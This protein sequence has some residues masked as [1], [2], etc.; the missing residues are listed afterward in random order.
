MEKNMKKLNIILLVFSMLVS[1]L[2]FAYENPSFYEAATNETPILKDSPVKAIQTTIIKLNQLTNVATYSPQMMGFLVNREITPLFDF[3][4]IA[5][6]V[7]SA[8]HVNL[9][10]EEVEYFANSLRQNVINTLL[11]KLA[12]GRSSSLDFVYARPM[13]GNMI[14]VRLNAK[15]Y[16][17][18]G[19]NVDLSFHKSKSGKWQIF[20]VALGHD[21]LIN[22]YQR[23]VLIK[24]RRYGVYGMLGRI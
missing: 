2:V 16:S 21:N 7:L 17:R 14:V 3:E 12:Q 20:D 24:V 9:N 8:S 22:Y 13:D 1:S 6:E 19:F 18:Y 23:M 5:D 15:G 4:Y 11:T 10:N